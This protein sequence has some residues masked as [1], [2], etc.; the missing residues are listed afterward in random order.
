MAVVKLSRVLLVAPRNELGILLTRLCQFPMFHP[1]DRH[2]LVEDSKI[3]LLS[4]R[5]HSIY[6]EANELLT[7]LPSELARDLDAARKTFEAK[8]VASLLDELRKELLSIKQ[9]MNACSG[10]ARKSVIYP[11]L[12]AL[13]EAALLTFNN[14]RRI[15]VAPGLKRFVAI[16]GFVP[17]DMA[18]A[19]AVLLEG[20]LVSAE[21]MRKRLSGE[22]YIPSLIVNPKI[23]SLFE[24]I[25][26]TQGVPRY[27]EIDPTPIVAF[28]FPVFFG[29][30]FADLGHGV[31]L[32]ALG[33]FLALRPAGKYR[34]WGRMLT[35]LGF[36]ASVSGS[37]VGVFFGIEFPTPFRHLTPFSRALAMPLTPQSALFLLEVAIVMGTFH[38]AAAYAI[39]VMNQYRSGNFAEA[40]LSHLPTLLLYSSA[41]PFGLA[42]LGVQFRLQE[43]F[44]SASDTPGFKELIGWHVP[45]SL[46]MTIAF[47]VLAGSFITLI[48]GRPIAYLLQ[49]N[50]HRI[51]KAFGEGLMEALLRPMEFLG[52][53]ISYARLGALLMIGTLLGSLINGVLEMGIIG[54]PLAAALHAAQ[55]AV[56]GFIVYIQD[57]RLHLYEWSSKFYLG[58]GIPF[59]PLQSSGEKSTI[60]WL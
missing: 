57:L 28:V 49:G 21:A 35:M 15:R 14:V 60:R 6:S 12:I 5:A 4:S 8:D 59:A 41:I 30:M 24:N 46:T 9:E 1:S 36:A 27:N 17:S 43:L 29:I 48:L 51:V 20:Y 55:M 40:F 54:I 56:E 45:I 31:A 44:T 37:I 11:R 22:P 32:L 34:Y 39:A 26:L 50:P 38:I 19:F 10:E 18:E 3:L 53:T 7:A 2:D 52:N 23:V 13:R 42:L 58:L 16:E 47:P 25:T 33:L